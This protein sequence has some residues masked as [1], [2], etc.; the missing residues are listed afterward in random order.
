MIAHG[1]EGRFLHWNFV[2][3][4]LNDLFGI[5]C[6]GGCMCAGPY[7]HRLLGIPR[8]AAAAIE[9]ELL[10]KNELLRPGFVRLSLSY[11]WTQETLDYVL[12][13]VL[14]VAERGWLFLPSYTF[15]VDSGC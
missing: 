12:Q 7:G 10:D 4:L 1:H 8:E 11:Y 13:A 9:A 14:F 2:A 15:Y 6:R 3:A 5:Q